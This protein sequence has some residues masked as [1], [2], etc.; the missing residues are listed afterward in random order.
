MKLD[1]RGASD[2][3]DATELAG[4]ASTDDEATERDETTVFPCRETTA[5]APA[6]AAEAGAAVALALCCCEW[7]ETTHAE[8]LLG[9]T[10]DRAVD[11]VLAAATGSCNSVMGTERGANGPADAGYWA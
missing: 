7:D 6:A 10:K 2:D 4:A 5:V 8:L 1:G 3:D 11:F 9:N